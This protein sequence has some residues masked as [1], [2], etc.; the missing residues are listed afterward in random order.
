MAERDWTVADAALLL[1]PPMSEAE[2]RALIVVSGIEP[3]G[4]RR[5]RGRPA[6]V[7][8]QAQLL[9]AHAAAVRLRARHAGR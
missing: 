2:V 7:Y 9:E 3:V 6:H 1:D 5:G 4:Q 8:D